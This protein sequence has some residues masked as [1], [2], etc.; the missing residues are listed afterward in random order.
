MSLTQRIFQYFKENAAICEELIFRKMLYCIPLLET[1]VWPLTLLLHKDIAIPDCGSIF[2]MI[3]D[4]LHHHMLKQKIGCVYIGKKMNILINNSGSPRWMSC[5]FQKRTGFQLLC[6][7]F[8]L[9]CHSEYKTKFSNPIS[10]TYV[11]PRNRIGSFFTI[12]NKREEMP[13]KHR[14]L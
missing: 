2:K 7:V 1:C 6:H 14:Y 11:H 9:S 5:S 10:S 12:K 3:N 13:S 8:K 4:Q